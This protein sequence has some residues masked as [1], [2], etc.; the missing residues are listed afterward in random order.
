MQ[1]HRASHIAILQATLLYG[2]LF[3]ASAS[4]TNTN[5]PNA[6]PSA[7]FEKFYTSVDDPR[8][9]PRTGLVKC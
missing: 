1:C 5:L 7:L 3:L 8:V 6:D 9:A 4:S 2:G